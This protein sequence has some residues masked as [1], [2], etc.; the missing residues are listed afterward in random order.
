MK[1]KKIV[2]K[3]LLWFLFIALV[4]LTSVTAITYFITRTSQ[5]KEVKNNLVYIAQSK[6]F[7]GQTIAA[8]WR[9]LPFLNRSILLQINTSEALSYLIALKIIV[10]VF[11]FVTL[12]VV[13]L[14]A[15]L[16]AKSILLPVVK[17]T[18]V[19]Q[20]L[21]GGNLNQQAPVLTR[22]E[23]DRLA[24]SFNFMGTQ[25]Q[26]SFQTIQAREQELAS[27]KEQLK[28]VLDAVPGSISWIDSEGTYMGVNRHLA[29][30]FNLSP[31]AFVGKKLGFIQENDKLSSFLREFINSP[32]NSASSIIDFEINQQKRYYIIAAQKYQQGSATVSVG[33]DITDRKQTE[34]ALKQ[35]EATNRA[36]IEAIP[37]L[38]LRVRGDG[39]YLDDA[40]G[41]GRV[42]RFS[43][44]NIALNATTVYDSLPPAQA[45]QRMDAIKRALETKTLQ[46]YEHQLLID[47]QL[48]DE[49]V[50]VIVIGENEVLVMVRDISDRKRAE[51]ALRIAEENYRSIFE[52]ALEGIFQSSPEGYY[53]NIN[54]AMARIYGYD[55]P[56]E[57]I[58]TIKDIGTQIYVDP[59]DQ[60][61]FKRQLEEN[62][63][64]KDFE[65]RVYQKDGNI[66]W[67]Q[68]DT[69]A[70]RDHTGQLL[71]YEGMIQDITDRKRR[72]DELRRQLEELKIEIDHKKR[73]KEVAM[74][75]GSS[76]FQEVQQEIAEVNLDEF[77][78]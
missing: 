59:L 42:K 54:S 37:D 32:E 38:L 12:L 8:D 9:Y 48:I 70:V 1:S 44:D 57:M 7:D 66:I 27:A 24:Q 16:V 36:L 68:E 40:V 58:E 47:G 30:K 67:I 35:S 45:Q 73:E 49:E 71:Y 50:R 39:V 77:W 11:G 25:L 10:I 56:Q 18:Q 20:E 22:E 69:R 75:T 63:Q 29:A 15:F 62:D 23:I 53:I 43:G 46:M 65:Y 55:S 33:I 6:V 72:E 13:I 31:E 28:A 74:L 64:V 61:E 52:N 19:V 21:A 76:Y 5:T 4:P 34:E 78:S 51:E 17:L 60:A 26:E 3:L 41:A 2:N 14:A